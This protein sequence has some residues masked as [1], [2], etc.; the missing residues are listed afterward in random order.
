VLEYYPVETKISSRH[1]VKYL[2][3]IL[4]NDFGGS[5]SK[6]DHCTF[7]KMRVNNLTITYPNS[8]VKIPMLIEYLLM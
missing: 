3:N 4:A 6:L 8:N 7:K 2:Q 1:P 5:L